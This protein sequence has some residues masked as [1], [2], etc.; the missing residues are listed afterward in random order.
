MPPLAR[1][2]E[3]YFVI[4]QFL[5]CLE[6][7]KKTTKTR[8]LNKTGKHFILSTFSYFSFPLPFPLIFH[9][10]CSFQMQEAYG[11]FTVYL[12]AR[13]IPHLH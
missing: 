6:R 2:M 12:L 3:N 13:V 7:L 4:V 11:V 10:L 9:L 5:L 8:N 1:C